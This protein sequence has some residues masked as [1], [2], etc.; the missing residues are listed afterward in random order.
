MRERGD[1]W[2]NRLAGRHIL[3]LVMFRRDRGERQRYIE[4]ERHRNK[5][6]ELTNPEQSRVAQLVYYKL[7]YSKSN[8][9]KKG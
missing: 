8:N 9:N 7:I 2:V 6:T 5:G 1:G 4:I 3:G